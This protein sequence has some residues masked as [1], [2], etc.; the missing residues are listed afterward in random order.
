[1]SI[2]VT[3][4][5]IEFDLLEPLPSMIQIE[6]I[7]HALSKQCRYNGHCSR[8]Y[9]VAEH[10]ILL[11]YLVPDEFKLE[12]LLHDASETYVGDCVSPLKSLLPE[13]KRIERGIDFEIRRKFNLPQHASQQI[14]FADLRIMQ[15]ERKALM[16]KRK[17][18]GFQ[19]WP[20]EMEFPPFRDL[21]IDKKE[22]YSS[23]EAGK[24][25]FLDRFEALA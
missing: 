20:C 24:A 2:I 21:V 14:K 18:G 4:S 10:S 1:M 25:A 19:H 9:S 7:A 3:H 17:P 5:G 16:P 13:F 6:D 23:T 8:F 22:Q 15:N 11:S 12:A